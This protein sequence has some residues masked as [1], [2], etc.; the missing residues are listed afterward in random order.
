M[1]DDPVNAKLAALNN[2]VQ[3][4]VDWYG[5]VKGGGRY[6]ADGGHMLGRKLPIAFTGVMLGDADIK[7]VAAS[8]AFSED[9]HLYL[10]AQAG[11]KGRNGQARQ[12]FNNTAQGGMVL[13]GK[14]CPAGMYEAEQNGKGGA[15]D[16]RDPL[17]LID[18]GEIPGDVYQACC[19]SIPYRN[20][21]LAV[22][23][24]PDLRTTW[25]N[26]VFHMYA[27]RW[28]N[29]GAWTKPDTKSRYI[30]LHG[31]SKNAGFYGSKFQAGMWAAYKGRVGNTFIGPEGLDNSV[32]GTNGNVYISPNGSD[33]N[34]GT[35]A[36]PL[37]SL[38][39]ALEA[40]PD[41]ST[42]HLRKGTYPVVDLIKSKKKL[43]SISIKPYNNEAVTVAGIKL[44]QAH[45]ITIEDLTIDG[46]LYFGGGVKNVIARKL[47]LNK[48][49]NFR[50]GASDIIVEDS[51]I[52]NP[53]GPGI[54][55]GSDK[56]HAPISNV[57]LRRNL[58][59]KIGVDAIQAKNFRNLVVEDNEI[60]HVKRVHPK[61]H[62]DVFQSVFGGDGLIIRRNYIHHNEGQGIFLSDGTVSNVLIE[63]NLLVN[64]VGPYITLHLVDVNGAVVVNNT[65]NGGGLPA[66]R[67]RA[68][69]V[70]LKNNVMHGLKLVEAPP[71]VED[72]N[73]IGTG[74]N[75]KNH[76]RH[77]FRG[78]ASF[79]NPDKT[80]Y[81]LRPGSPGVDAADAA[82]APSLDKVGKARRDNPKTPN[83]GT[84]KIN[85]VD[86]GAYESD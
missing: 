67:K 53:T 71:F 24:M 69:G 23:L 72:Y 51:R 18:G 63:N 16:C 28:A 43:N 85:Y 1:S 35:L 46:G 9:S 26:E 33:Q 39:A 77:T 55:F 29:H 7:A 60:S 38:G 42:I 19:T 48:T 45:N 54:N 75:Y 25:D 73:L 40:V 17:G 84:G 27:D 65:I 36:N 10:S 57:T 5:I 70:V 56:K 61:A 11:E 4:G 15:R 31:S 44:Q 13:F 79:V 52:T 81:R 34:I 49:L 41:G 37:K 32:I 80:D 58:I 30:E 74:G 14:V 20:T 78:S 86:M 68:N 6:S 83:K 3:A 8:G 76:G 66:L 12:Y 22:R 82:A 21:S 47:D 2:Y 50:A 59:T 64:N 62:P